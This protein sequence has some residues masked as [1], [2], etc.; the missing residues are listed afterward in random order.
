[1]VVVHRG[2]RWRVVDGRPGL[3]G[4]RIPPSVAGW[5]V[6]TRSLTARLRRGCPDG[7]AVHLQAQGWRRP[8]L[9]E[10]RRLG[11]DP[12]ERAWIR[13]VALCCHGQP[14][15]RARTVLPRRSLGGANARLRRL[16]ARPLGALLFRGRGVSPGPLEVARLRRRDWLVARLGAAT[17]GCWA[18][19]VVHTLNGHPLLVTEIFLPEVIAW[20]T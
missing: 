16:G 20:R 14:L 7:F 6:R 2:C 1:M 11:I 12:R 9:E 3:P 5:L 4:T 18:R 8:A 15:I 10:A 19:R 17:A 13:E